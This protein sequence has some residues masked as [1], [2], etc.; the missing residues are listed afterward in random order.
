M[1][2]DLRYAKSLSPPQLAFVV[3]MHHTQLTRRVP[4]TTQYINHRPF[5][6]S[7]NHLVSRLFY[8]LFKPTENMLS[9]EDKTIAS[10]LVMN[11]F[12]N[13]AGFTFTFNLP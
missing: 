5:P 10:S 12:K 3:S 6:R 2:S 13:S 11:Y 1:R 9:S 8:F 4:V 7:R